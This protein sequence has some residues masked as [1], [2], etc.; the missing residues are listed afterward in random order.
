RGRLGGSGA[1][2]SAPSPGRGAF[3]AGRRAGRCHAWTLHHLDPD[4]R[5]S[6]T[7]TRRAAASSGGTRSGGEDLHEL[8]G[9]RDFELVIT[10]VLRSF[11][12]PPAQEERRVAEAIPL[13]VVIPHLADA[14]DPQRFPRQVLTCTPA[15]LRARHAARCGGGA[16]PL[17]PGV[18]THRIDAKGREL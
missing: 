13:H 10:A 8:V 5:Q 1:L 16:G 15:A 17:A 3:A 6:A 2:E 4:P 9:L 7:R 14:L 12:G 18:I 11:V